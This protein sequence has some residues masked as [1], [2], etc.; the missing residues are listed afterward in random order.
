[1]RFETWCA[2]GRRVRLGENDIFVRSEGTGDALLFLHGFPTS[3]LDF[4]GTAAR[5]KDSFRCLTFDFLGFGNSDKPSGP[6]T[7]QRQADLACSV[8]MHHNVSRAFVVAHDYGV[9]VGQELLARHA[10]GTL[11]FSLAGVTFMNGGL[12]PS[13]H[14]PLVVQRL[15]ASPV[16]TVLAPLFVNRLTLRRS[17]AR[18]MHKPE[19]LD[20]NEHWKAIALRN[21]TS[22]MPALLS[23]IR[24]RR[25]FSSRWRDAIRDAVVPLSFAWGLR[26]PISGA[27]ML[28]WVRDLR[29]DARVLA[30]DQAGHYPQLEQ[31][32]QVS[33]FI[34]K[35]VLSAFATSDTKS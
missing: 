2:T 20:I 4:A 27:H 28:D 23:Y 25:T 10:E 13:L 9:S 35:V 14:R 12:T 6:Y 24:E 19:T 30:L 16:G 7:Y 8:A 18:I 3:S 1:M 22:R 17:L 21:G 34:K 15:L 5:L 11:P 26:D 32:S 29:A 31:E 33:E